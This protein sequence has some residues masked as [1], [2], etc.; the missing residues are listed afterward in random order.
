MPGDQCL[1]V[2][3]VLEIGGDFSPRSIILERMGLPNVAID[4]FYL[5][6]LHRKGYVAPNVSD[7]VVPVIS[8]DSG[9]LEPTPGCYENVVVFDFQNV[10]PSLIRVFKIDPLARVK[11]EVNP[12]TMPAG[13]RF[14]GSEHFLPELF[15]RLM[16]HQAEAGKRGLSHITQATDLAMKTIC[17]S[18]GAKTC[19]FFQADLVLVLASAESWLVKTTRAHLESEGYEVYLADS[20]N[21]FVGLGDGPDPVGR[22]KALGEKLNQ[23]WHDRL[24]SEFGLSTIEVAWNG[25]FNQLVIPPNKRKEGSILKRYAG[26]MVRDGAPQLVLEGIEGVLSDWTELARNLSEELFNQFFNDG[27]GFEKWLIEEMNQLKEGARDDQLIYR[28][29]IRKDPASYAKNPP[30][31]IKAAL[32]LPKHGQEIRYVFTKHSS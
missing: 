31:H 12:V 1:P 21:L 7:D 3:H 17:K 30:P 22:G 32:M 6:K 26:Q 10:F 29:R 24:Q 28:K 14:S 8:P 13:Y 5:P 16:A 11:A 2:W 27:E 25:H 20:E 18:L 23:F 4:H 15:E 19:R 9:E